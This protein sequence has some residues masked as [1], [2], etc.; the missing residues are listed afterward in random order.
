MMLSGFFS[1]LQ[2]SLLGWTWWSAKE[3]T[4]FRAVKSL[5]LCNVN[6]QPIAILADLSHPLRESKKGD[7]WLESSAAV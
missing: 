6:L 4:H 5:F 7:T 2:I 3:D 1:R